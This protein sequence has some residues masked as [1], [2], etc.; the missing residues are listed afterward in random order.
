MSV[1]TAAREGVAAVFGVG[2]ELRDAR[3]LHPDG[4]AF[5]ATLTTYG[6]SWGSSVL[7][8]PGRHGAI[9]RVSRALGLPAA[10]PDIGGL[11]VRLPGRGAGGGP[12]D[13]LLA[14]T[15]TAPVLRHV[16]LPD[17]GRRTHCSLLP[18]VTGSRRR[19]VLGARRRGEDWDLLVAT[20]TGPWQR[21]GSLS[22]EQP[23]GQGESERLRFL[24][25]LGA[26][27]LQPVRLLRRLR[28]RAYA[29]SQAHRP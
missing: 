9:A 21:W 20:L 7:D 18:Y 29:R 23:L 22:L 25:T 28:A 8:N 19:V 27:D 1:L 10:W 3:V 24:P 16:L 4:T 6:G 15:G 12:L 5:Q 13:I 2:S 26:P 11:A 14:T 17:A